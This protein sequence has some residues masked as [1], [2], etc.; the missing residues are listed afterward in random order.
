MRVG[1][2]CHAHPKF[3]MFYFISFVYFELTTPTQ[4]IPATTTTIPAAVMSTTPPTA[5]SSGGST[6]ATTIPPSLETQDGG[7]SCPPQPLSLAF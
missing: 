6:L 4:L 7:V 2:G 3:D 5:V 1:M